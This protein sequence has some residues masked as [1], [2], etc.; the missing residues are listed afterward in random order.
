MQIKKTHFDQIP[1]L[2]FS[3]E[4][5][6][7]ENAGR[8]K[9]FLIDEI[10]YGN[11]EFLIFQLQINDQKFSSFKYQIL[12]AYL[13]EI[14]KYDYDI[15]R[16]IQGFIKATHFTFSKI[17]FSEFQKKIKSLNENEMER[18]FSL[19]PEAY[20]ENLFLIAKKTSKEIIL[21]NKLMHT[22]LSEVDLES[23][24]LSLK[25]FNLFECEIELNHWTAD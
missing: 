21:L 23:G 20:P 24:V 11:S 5:N 16:K 7:H 17:I 14:L 13:K 18:L 15:C 22:H 1:D 3:K 19:H 8:Y 10:K 25:R 6:F 9:D 12:E 4:Y 2:I